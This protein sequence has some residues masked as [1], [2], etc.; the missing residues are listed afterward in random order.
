MFTLR[1][2]VLLW[3]VYTKVLVLILQVIKLRVILIKYIAL[4]HKKFCFQF[5]IN[6]ALKSTDI[7][8]QEKS[9]ETEDEDNDAVINKNFTF[10]W[11]PIDRG[12]VYE[13]SDQFTMTDS[14]CFDLI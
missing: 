13:A 11:T 8:N 4:L 5:F 2:K 12:Q 9:S 1:Q 7:R 14:K 3:S 10:E 6:I